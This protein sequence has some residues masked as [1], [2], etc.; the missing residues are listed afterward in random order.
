MLQLPGGHARP[1]QRR[2]WILHRDRRL[3]PARR[4]RRCSSLLRQR[5]AHALIPKPASMSPQVSGLPRPL[6]FAKLLRLQC[7]LCN[8]A[9]AKRQNYPNA[10]T[11]TVENEDYLMTWDLIDVS[12]EWITLGGNRYI[13]IFII[14]KS[15][16]T[17]TILHKD[18]SNFEKILKCA[19][20]KAGFT[21]KR[22]RCYCAEFVSKKLQAFL[23][24][25]HITAEYS[26]PWPHKQFGNSMSEKFVDTLRKMMHTL[27]LQSQLPPEFWGAA[28]HYATNVYNHLPHDSLRGKIPHQ[29]HHDK[30]PDVSWFRPF[31]CHATLFRGSELVDHHKLAPRGEH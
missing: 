3:S 11:T 12:E 6:H 14:K 18:L 17:I 9:K 27:L 26:N 7:S 29:I 20:T 19:I 30:R 5:M 8:T 24:E 2:S 10:S 16:Y 22:V 23:V 13:S 21:P 31:G 1:P 25:Q 15:R 4:P 28:A